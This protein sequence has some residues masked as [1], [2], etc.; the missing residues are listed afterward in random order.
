MAAGASRPRHVRASFARRALARTVDLAPFFACAWTANPFMFVVG[1]VWILVA[2]G[3][4]PGGR[5]PGKRLLGLRV[6][7]FEP[8]AQP[9]GPDVRESALRNLPLGIV[10]LLGIHPIGWV[11]FPFVGL[12]VVVAEVWLSFRDPDGRRLGDRFAGTLVASARDE[13]AAAVLARPA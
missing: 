6:A 12:A 13:G 1:V 4:I 2:D 5:S 9:R 7:F 11:L 3:V 8:L 10:A